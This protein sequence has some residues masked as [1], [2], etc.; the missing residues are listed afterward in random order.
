MQVLLPA[1]IATSEPSASCMPSFHKLTALNP[2]TREPLVF[3]S[4]TLATFFGA[5]SAPTP[6]YRVYQQAFAVSPLLMT[7]IFAVYA[8]ALLSALLVAGSVSDHLGR[9]SVIFGALLLEGLAMAL[10]LMAESAGLLVAAR[11]V[12]GIATG[13]ACA[14]IGAALIDVDR[15]RGQFVNSIAPLAGMAIGARARSR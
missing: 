1:A 6:L 4:I 14:S 13:I 11:S 15:S 2:V 9:R 12:Q 10:F 3:H 8:V 7:V 5:A